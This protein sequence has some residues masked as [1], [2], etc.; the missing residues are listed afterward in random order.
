[1]NA[2]VY[3]GPD[4]PH[5]DAQHP[6]PQR[7]GTQ[8]PDKRNRPARKQAGTQQT[9][10]VQDAAGKRRPSRAEARQAD[11]MQHIARGSE[12]ARKADYAQAEQEY[13]AALQIDPDEPSCT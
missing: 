5:T 1:V 11:E 4:A 2:A 12:L 10:A 8:H 9:N 3:E 7:A 13:R 6:D